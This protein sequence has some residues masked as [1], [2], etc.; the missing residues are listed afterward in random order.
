MEKTIQEGENEYWQMKLTS[1]QSIHRVLN[2]Q[3]T[4]EQVARLGAQMTAILSGEAEE[5]ES[6]EIL[7]VTG[8]EE[9]DQGSDE[10]QQSETGDQQ[11]K[12]IAQSKNGDG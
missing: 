3:L 4:D 8:Q 1:D 5:I 12:N 6:L 2:P 9:E 10:E 11:E 7:E